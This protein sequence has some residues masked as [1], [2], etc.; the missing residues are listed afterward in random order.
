M[1]QPLGR[2]PGRELSLH[3]VDRTGGQ[4]QPSRDCDAESVEQRSLCTVGLCD[5]SEPN[6]W[7]ALDGHHDVDTLD[8]GHLLDEGPGT[9]AETGTAL[10]SLERLPHTEGQE[11]DEDVRLDSLLLLVPDRPNGQLALDDA[12]RGLGL[13]ELDAVATR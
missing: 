4:A 13:R 10:P 7:T 9:V 5:A 6:L 8:P 3:L 1:A 11:A 2:I 12:E